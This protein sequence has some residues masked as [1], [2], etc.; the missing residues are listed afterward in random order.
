MLAGNHI[1][2]LKS[3]FLAT[4]SCTLQM[5]AH[6]RKRKESRITEVPV[7][8]ISH[9]KIIFVV[10]TCTVLLLLK[11]SPRQCNSA[12]DLILLNTKAWQLHD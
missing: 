12:T 8:G 11:S 9:K 7:G 4:Y 2:S 1:S 10:G 3:N 5:C 6:S